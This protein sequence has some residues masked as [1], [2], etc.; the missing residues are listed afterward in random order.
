MITIIRFSD[1]SCFLCA[2]HE[3]TVEVRF[4]DRSFAGVVCKD[5]LFELM[6]RQ[7]AGGKKA[8]SDETA[9]RA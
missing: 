1:K 2:S 6:K 5:H 4:K 7:F 8:G 9:G 3:D